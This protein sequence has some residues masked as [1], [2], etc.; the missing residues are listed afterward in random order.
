MRRQT[1]R[2]RA[3]LVHLIL[4]RSRSAWSRLD[5]KEIGDDLSRAGVLE[6]PWSKRDETISHQTAGQGTL[7]QVRMD[8]QPASHPSC[9]RKVQNMNPDDWASQS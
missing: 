6:G 9:F 8:S 3:A 5:A 2:L 1:E 7:R 4:P